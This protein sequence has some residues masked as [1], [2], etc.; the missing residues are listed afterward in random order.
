VA[1]SFRKEIESGGFFQL[2]MDPAVF[3]SLGLPERAE[4]FPAWGK[5]KI[6]HECRKIGSNY[7]FFLLGTAQIRQRRLKKDRLLYQCRSQMHVKKNS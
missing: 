5:V 3:L 6:R 1:L 2:S 4:T 7:G